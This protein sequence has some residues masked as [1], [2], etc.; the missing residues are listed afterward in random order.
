MKKLSQEV[1]KPAV[2]KSG[3]AVDQ[4]NGNYG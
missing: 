3:D 4:K 1:G 2:R